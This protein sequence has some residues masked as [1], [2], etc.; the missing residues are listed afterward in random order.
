MNF[1]IPIYVHQQ[2]RGYAARPLFLGAPEQTDGNLNRLLTRLTR[3][4]LAHL[5]RL[6]RDAR[7]EPI[8]AWTFGPNVTT[9]R[10]AL[11]IAMRRRAARVKYL[12][13]TFDHMG[14]RLAFSPSVPGLWFEVARNEPLELRA[15]SVFTEH[16]RKI[17]READ[18]EED[19]LPETTNLHGKAGVQVLD[20]SVHIPP[21]APR[22]RRQSFF[23]GRRR[24]QDG[25]D[26]TARIGRC[27]DWLYP[28]ELERAV[29]RD[30]EAAELE[31]LLAG[32]DRR[33]VL[34]CGPR[35]ARQD[36]SGSRMR[37]SRVADANRF[38]FRGKMSGLVS[39][40][41]LISGMSY[42]G[43]WEGRLLAS[44]E[45]ARSA[46]R[47]VLRTT[48]WVCF[49]RDSS[50]STLNAATVLARSWSC[51]KFACSARFRPRD[52]AS[53]RSAR[54]RLRGPLPPH[55]DSRAE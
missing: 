51:R 12:V 24:N 42:V 15:Q 22:R 21:V 55:S 52:F 48:L 36:R 50:C 25:R 18:D 16:W 14:R 9:H 26:R 35:M 29:Y 1:R 13:V 46:T 2:A 44:I 39:P 8:A 45:D 31:R 37:S 41:R 30:R 10:V 20:L 6:G 40:Q 28:D 47:A 7:H 17:E 54:P 33:P 43:Q 34:L 27:L 32:A 23:L 53:C 49:S 11:E 3:E 19:V 4:I 5:E 38:T